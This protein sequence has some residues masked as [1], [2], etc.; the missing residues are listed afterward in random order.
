M[1]IE[2]IF[3]KFSHI[4]KF[5]NDYDDI[6]HH[7]LNVCKSAGSL[8]CN[9]WNLYGVFTYD[10]LYNFLKNKLINNFDDF[11]MYDRDIDI[12]KKTPYDIISIILSKMKY[13]NF[14]FVYISY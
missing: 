10:E 14:N 8:I 2:T 6:S 9:E 1:G 11:V 5:D 12:N 13:Y 4:E 3:Y 7:T